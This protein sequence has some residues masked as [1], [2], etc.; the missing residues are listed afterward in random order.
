MDNTVVAE[1]KSINGRSASCQLLTVARLVC[2][3]PV[4]ARAA[5]PLNAVQYLVGNWS[6]QYEGGS[7]RISY[8][9]K[10]AYE[11]SGSWLRERD[12]FKNGGSDEESLTF[13]PKHAL[14]TAVI[15]DSLGMTT[16]FRASGSDARHIVYHS[17][18][19]DATM[20]ETFD[21]LSSA[22]YTL[23]YAQSTGGKLTKSLDTWIPA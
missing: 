21:R 13:D 2:A 12:S 8:E 7:Q 22:R 4:L 3:L 5:T 9:S 18:Y 6:C 11:L 14:W 20:T 10:Y 17:V 16:I 15:L 1:R 23:H 19:P